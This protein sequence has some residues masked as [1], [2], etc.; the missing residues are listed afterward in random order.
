MLVLLV[1]AVGRG[2]L[3]IVELH[4]LLIPHDASVHAVS[5]VVAVDRGSGST[6]VRRGELT[7]VG[8]IVNGPVGSGLTTRSSEMEPRLAIG[9]RGVVRHSSVGRGH[10]SVSTV[11]VG[12]L[13]RV[14]VMTLGHTVLWWTHVRS[15]LRSIDFSE[16]IDVLQL[17]SSEVSVV[18]TS[19]SSVFSETT[20]AATT[21]S[22]TSF[23]SAAKAERRVFSR[24]LGL[25]SLSVR[26]VSD[27]RKDRSN[28]LDE[29]NRK[30][31]LL[32]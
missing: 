31:L 20:S 24:K 19:S 27:R 23:V 17:R 14:G 29:L 7:N 9:S 6:F 22:A 16:R 30:H 8:A 13:V 1:V 10:V 2:Q 25:D 32:R 4:K 11:G 21:T 5:V 26:G 3:T 15:S 12:V 28:T 18:S